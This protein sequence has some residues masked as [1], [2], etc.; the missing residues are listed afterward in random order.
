MGRRAAHTHSSPPFALMQAAA[1]EL[2]RTSTP[3]P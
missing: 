2:I 3:L 1:S